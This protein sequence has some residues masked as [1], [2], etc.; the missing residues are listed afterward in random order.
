MSS[1]RTSTWSWATGT[2]PH[3][4]HLP[5]KVK[6]SESALAIRK[7]GAERR[8][9]LR[10]LQPWRLT[11]SLNSARI[12]IQRRTYIILSDWRLRRPQRALMRAGRLG[13]K[14]REYLMLFR[15]HT[16]PTAARQRQPAQKR[17]NCNEDKN[18]PPTCLDSFTACRDGGEFFR[19]S[20]HRGFGRNGASHGSG[21]YGHQSRNAA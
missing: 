18:V 4:K 5:G 20:R 17:G 6:R 11:L 14:A 10:R 15:F 12:W 19:S 13:T 8:I 1:E 3:L 21:G 9:Q 7:C 2:G 16:P